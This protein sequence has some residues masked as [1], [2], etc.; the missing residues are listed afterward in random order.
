LLRLDK[1]LTILGQAKNFEIWEQERKWEA[2]ARRLFL[3]QMRFGT[4]KLGNHDGIFFIDKG[5]WQE[6]NKRHG[7]MNPS[8]S[9]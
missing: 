6:H 3:S 8:Y 4:Y 2:S 7:S 1:K 9:W 5:R